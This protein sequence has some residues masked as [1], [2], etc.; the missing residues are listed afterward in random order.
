MTD[1]QDSN[2]SVR[3]SRRSFLELSGSTAVLT[4]GG[5]M[6]QAGRAYAAET[7]KA[8]RMG[9]IG[10]GFGATFHWHEH[11]NCV[12][13]G[14]TD[15]R[16]D[17]RQRLRKRYACDA[18]YDS[19]EEMIKQARDIDAVAIFSGADQHAE[20]TRMCMERGWHV[21]SACPTC[22]TLDE[23]EMLI[24]LKRK[25]GMRYM[26]AE[27]S[28]YR[29]ECI[30]ARNM[31]RAGGFGELFYTEAE[32]YHDRGDLEK[33]VTNKQSRFYHP[34][35]RPNWRVGMPPLMYPT[36]CLAF[37]VGVTGERIT[38]VSCLG[39]GSDHPFLKDNVYGNPYW[40]ETSL[41]K[42]D[43]GHMVRCNM[44]KLC[45]AGG[46]RAQ[47][48]GDSATL[49][50]PNHGVHS[51]AVKKVR[52]KGDVPVEI[53]EYWKSDMLP[54]PMRHPSGHGGSAVFISAEFVNALLENREPEINLYDSLA[55]TAP[56]IVAHQSATKDGEQLPVPQ[57]EKKKV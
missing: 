29:Q 57:F 56:G 18:A 21:V 36:H 3:L 38:K 32:Y 42:T 52:M 2:S 40:N 4:A 26:M 45:A 15:L 17:R 55:M 50:M 49:Y 23:A 14:V 8:I 51:R 10:G 19:L 53:P 43:K 16:P 13:T 35:G 20:H 46:E 11:P 30:F 31:Y 1:R 41:M 25:T 33:L 37:V 22:F 27:S 39:W 24:E 28:W 44:F 12:V 7:G 47:W 5:L 6:T 54:E 34:D 48:F 9:V